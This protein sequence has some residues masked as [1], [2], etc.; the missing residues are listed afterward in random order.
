MLTQIQEKIKN[1]T[2]IKPWVTQGLLQSI[3]KRDKLHK[4]FLKTKNTEIK[5]NYFE[6]YKIHKNLLT[7]LLRKSKNNHFKDYFFTHK[8]NLSKVWKAIQQVTNTKTKENSSPRLLKHNRN[9]I[10]QE[11]EIAQLINDFYGSVAQKTKE[12]IL[13]TTKHFIDILGQP[14]LNSIFLY[15]TTPMAIHKMIQNLAD[16]KASGP[17]SI[18]PQN[19]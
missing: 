12:K 6:Q 5:L 4:I 8:T 18:P 3:R 15:P 19:F 1:T 14:N 16:S 9:N 17:Y 2:P 7:K 10:T 11:N 13:P